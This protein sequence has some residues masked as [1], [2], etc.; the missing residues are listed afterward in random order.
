LVIALLLLL[1]GCHP[2]PPG[3]LAKVEDSEVILLRGWRDMYSDGIN[4]LA[5]K[6]EAD[7]YRTAVYGEAQWKDVADA[8]VA[9]GAVVQGDAFVL[10]GFSYG[11]DHAIDIARRLDAAKINVPFMI[12]IDPVTPPKVPVRV[13]ETYNYY[14]SDFWDFLPWFRGVP[15]KSESAYPTVYNI[16]VHDRT[17]LDEPKMAHKTIA[18]SEKVHR[19][20][21]KQIKNR[22]PRG[23]M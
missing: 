7:G 5:T 4:E 11:A 23:K 20:I 1:T 16:D 9:R 13:G 19:D 22:F 8:L 2:M 15:L 12:T 17:D 10:I 18:A 6:I 14:Q 21:V 3:D